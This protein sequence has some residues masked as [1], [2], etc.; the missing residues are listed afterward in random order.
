MDSGRPVVI[1]NIG[2]VGQMNPSATTVNNIYY[3]DQFVPEE[4]KQAAAQSAK[5]EDT[6]ANPADIPVKAADTPAK[7]STRAAKPERKSTLPKPMPQPANG[8]V[9]ELMT[10]SKR[11]ITDEHLKLLFQQMMEDGWISKESRADYFLELFS[12][13]RSECTIIW[14]GK[15]GKGTLVYFFKHI[16]FEGL[17]SVPK[18]FTIPNILMGHFVDKE[19]NLLTHLDKGDPVCEKCGKEVM[20]YVRILKINAARAGRRPAREEY[21][22]EEEFG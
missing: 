17:I 4:V 10:F 21:E 11:G 15:Y 13:E 9:R 19:G 6:P 14:E 16:E 22:E 12:G 2:N 20:E 18:G 8:K 7:Q 3:G 5:A 1:Y